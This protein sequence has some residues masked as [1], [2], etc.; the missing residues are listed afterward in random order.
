MPL[1]LFKSTDTNAPVLTGQAGKLTDLLDA[2]LVNGYATASVTGITRSSTTATVTIAANTTLRTGDYITISG[3]S[4]TD[5]NVTAQITV[6]SGTQFT[7]AVSNSPTTPA[8]GTILYAKA[9]AGWATAYTGT[10]KRAYRS[11]NG[12]S[13]RFYVRVDDSTTV[14]NVREAKARGYETMSDVDTGTGPFPTVAQA[15]DGVNWNK[16]STADSTARPWF[17][18]A[19]DKTFYF[20]PQVNG[21]LSSG[22]TSPLLGFG[23]FNSYKSADVFNT[24]IGGTAVTNYT[25]SAAMAG[26]GSGLLFSVAW[27][28]TATAYT[29]IYIAR[30]Y[31][32]T[33]GSIAGALF[34]SRTYAAPTTASSIIGAS[35][36]GVPYPNGPDSGLWLCPIFVVDFT[37]AV[38]NIRGRLPGLFSHMHSSLPQAT[39]DTVTGV[40]GLSGL[41]LMAAETTNYAAVA[42]NVTAKGLVYI[43]TTGPW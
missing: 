40:V 12:A 6:L 29:P 18:W 9:A 23:H 27:G 32:Q 22:T 38:F 21:S 16:S 5:Y 15:A 30:S 17:L 35:T 19:D 2:C 14:G 36:S 1:Q 43:D 8:T 4:E 37:G 39:Y 20:I 10:N 13:N 42:G 11:P 3:A 25:G 28:A 33:G 26:A 41:T 24:F 31:S 34:D 7:Y